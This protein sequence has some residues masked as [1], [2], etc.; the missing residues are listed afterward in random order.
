[1][2]KKKEERTYGSI[3]QQVAI[4]LR[5]PQIPVHWD[6]II[7]IGLPGAM[8]L[9][10]FVTVKKGCYLSIFPPAHPS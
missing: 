3:Y 2:D 9:R 6:V 5:E 7:V 4:S 8:M 10:G 1:M